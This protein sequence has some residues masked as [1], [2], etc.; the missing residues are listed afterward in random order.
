MSERRQTSSSDVSQSRERRS[1]MHSHR[2]ILA[3]ALALSCAAA[4]AAAVYGVQS[5]SAV[6]VALAVQS[7]LAATATWGSMDAIKVRAKQRLLLNTEADEYPQVAVRDEPENESAA[8]SAR[9]QLA[10]SRSMHFV[11]LAVPVG[12]AAFFAGF[13]LWSQSLVVSATTQSIQATVLSMI[14]LAVSCLWLVLAKSFSSLAV[15]APSVGGEHEEPGDES[16]LPEAAALAQVFRESQWAALVAGIAILLGYVAPAAP[17]WTARIILIWSIAVSAEQILRIIFHSY[18][19]PLDR[20]FQSPIQLFLREAV[21]VRANPVAS[22]LDTIEARFG[23]SLRSSWAILFVRKAVAPIVAILALLLWGLTSLAVVETHQ[24]GVREHF[25]RRV[26]KPLGP[27]LHWSLPWPMGRIRQFPVKTISTMQIGFQDARV[28][29]RMEQMKGLLWTKPHDEEFALV[30]ADGAEMVAVNAIIYF[31][32]Q[33]DPELFFDYVYHTQNAESALEAYAYRVLMEQTR[34]ATLDEVLSVNRRQFVIQLTQSLRDYSAANRLGLDVIDVSLVN[35]HPPVGAAPAYL[36]TISATIDADRAEIEAEGEV[37]AQH[38]DVRR[39]S[40]ATVNQSHM[41]AS[42]RFGR[43][44]AE[45]ET[46]SASRQ[47][48]RQEGEAFKTR[49]FFDTLRDLLKDKRI[50]LVDPAL[51]DGSDQLML[52]LR[53]VRD[54]GSVLLRGEKPNE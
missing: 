29:G 14:C 54:G 32:I 35:L 15:D 39:Q 27:G 4:V 1:A 24:F 37:Q 44:A 18:L 46:Y 20:P 52:D 7:A 17:L 48:Y 34:S 3:S 12:I 53:D 31:K 41:E 26:E 25:G 51:N 8:D 6:F 47:V 38:Q 9:Q 23:L 21:L 11:F 50:V 28:S 43:A 45:T 22:L 33:E 16:E 2:S 19:S 13:Q 49:L 30:L 42:R 5:A 40:A 36:D 10:E